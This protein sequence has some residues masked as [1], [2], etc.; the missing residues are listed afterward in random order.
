MNNHTHHHH[1]V[2]LISTQSS[3]DQP[4]SLG[5]LL[6]NL[7]SNHPGNQSN[8]GG[9]NNKYQLYNKTTE[10]KRG[11]RGHDR[12]VKISCFL[13]EYANCKIDTRIYFLSVDCSI[14]F[15][16]ERGM[17]FNATLNNIPFTTCV[18]SAYN[19]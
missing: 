2:F 6:I 12:N 9:I 19:H 18:I 11:R 14:Y 13:F 3:L 10:N 1:Q 4:S 16:F 15:I 5:C 17:V 8:E 7:L